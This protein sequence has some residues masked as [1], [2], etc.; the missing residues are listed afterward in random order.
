MGVGIEMGM[1]L[2][3][4]IEMGVGMGTGMEMGIGMYN[5]LHVATPDHNKYFEN[6]I[7]RLCEN[8]NT[9]FLLS[10]KM[11][12]LQTSYNPWPAKGKIS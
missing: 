6:P 1:G 5:F 10:G 7:P 8:T 12:L 9:Q 2:D 3:V 11:P 4:V